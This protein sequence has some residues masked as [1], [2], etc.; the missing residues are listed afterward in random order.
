MS[1]FE[2][3]ELGPVP[4]GEDCAQT[5]D[6]DYGVKAH[7]ECQRY[8]AQLERHYAS[9]HQGKPF[10]ARLFTKSNPHDF[11]SY[12][13]VAVRFDPSDETQVEAAYWL[14]S[15]QPEMWDITLTE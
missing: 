6:P 4:S 11:G 1:R 5:V 15:N 2:T 14:E 3:L 10:P 8:R 9:H 13:E 12:Y 7:A